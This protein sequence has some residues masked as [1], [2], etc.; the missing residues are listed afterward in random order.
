VRLL[1]RINTAHKL[2]EKTGVEEYMNEALLLSSSRA[3]YSTVLVLLLSSHF[4]S[5]Y[6]ITASLRYEIWFTLILK[7]LGEMIAEEETAGSSCI[8]LAKKVLHD[9]RTYF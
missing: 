6:N 3:V 8:S 7:L 1:V 4:G 5:G 2:Q 9:Q